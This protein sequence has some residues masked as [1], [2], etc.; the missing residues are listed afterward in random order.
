MKNKM[1][2]IK[3]PLSVIDGRQTNLKDT[4]SW[5]LHYF[6]P[7][8]KN[9]DIQ[10][11]IFDLT[12]SE[13]E[14]WKEDDFNFFQV[15]TND[16][17]KDIKADYHIDCSEAYRLPV[18]AHIILYDPPYINLKNRKDKKEREKLYAYNLMNSLKN[19]EDL[20]RD[21][22]MSSYALLK[23]E[24]RLIAKITN[25]HYGK[26]QEMFGCYEYKKWFSNYFILVDDIIYRFY[27]HIPNL[28]QYSKKI[29][30]THSHFMIFK[31]KKR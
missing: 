13:M 19:L 18:S 10:T 27:K 3:Y 7:N 8:K 29:A 16:I 5:I 31:P 15:I 12:C 2:E 6:D 1:T 14:M 22:A 30:M 9:P 4:F 17:N 23:P 20:T 26:D 24:G 28:A 11:T 25:F 21:T